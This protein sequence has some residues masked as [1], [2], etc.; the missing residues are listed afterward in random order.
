MRVRG[1]MTRRGVALLALT[2][3]VVATAVVTAAPASAVTHIGKQPG[4][5]SFSQQS[6]GHDAMPTWTSATV[7]PAPFNDGGQASIWNTDGTLITTV[8]ATNPNVKSAPFSSNIDFVMGQ[9][10][11]FQLV[12]T[13]IWYEWVVECQDPILNTDPEQSM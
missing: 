11:D 2:G 4:Q 9:Y 7:C 1:S 10:V 12:Q 8:G 3:A 5:M 13:G 6:G